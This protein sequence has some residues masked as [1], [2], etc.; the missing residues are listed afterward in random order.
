MPE[1]LRVVFTFFH[2]WNRCKGLK[3]V[4]C[5]RGQYSQ[6]VGFCISL[7]CAKE[8]FVITG[9][10]AVIE[11]DYYWQLTDRTSPFE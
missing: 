5:T 7:K 9:F 11:S 3:E 4:D 2:Y 10:V 1:T 8:I 6:S